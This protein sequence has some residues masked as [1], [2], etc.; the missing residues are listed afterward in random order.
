MTM[1]LSNKTYNRLKWFITIFLPAFMGLVAGFGALGFIS[2]AEV[3]VA[4]IGLIGT[5][6][7]SLINVS[8]KN[9]NNSQEGNNG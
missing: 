7:G 4:A 8:S 1:E 6:L 2:N 3:I 9:Y 5:F